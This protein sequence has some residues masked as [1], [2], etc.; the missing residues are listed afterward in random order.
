M[1][2]LLTLVQCTVVSSNDLTTDTC[3]MYRCFF[4]WSH[5]WHLYNLPLSLRMIS[6]L[7][8]VQ[9]TVVSS[10]DLTTDTCTMY[11]YLFEWSHYWHLY[12]VP[13]SLRMISLLTLVQWELRL[14]RPGTVDIRE[15]L[16]LNS[17]LEN[18]CPEGRASWSPSGPSIRSQE[19]ILKQ[20][21]NCYFPELYKC[22]TVQFI[23]SG[24]LHHSSLCFGQ[25][26]SL[27]ICKKTFSTLLTVFSPTYEFP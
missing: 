11:R 21:I 26:A 12:N 13:L 9:C 22:T 18:K 8:H 5:Y 23:I 14:Q 27:N 4:E 10:N 20:V 1:I 2:S 15:V 17:G 24:S 3:T 6:L 25:L 16:I 19:F 7:T